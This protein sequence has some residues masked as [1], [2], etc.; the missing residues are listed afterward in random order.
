MVVSFQ[1][2]EE[3]QWNVNA[4]DVSTNGKRGQR[5]S[6]RRVRS[7]RHM[8]GIKSVSIKLKMVRAM[9]RG[10]HFINHY[11]LKKTRLIK[12]EKANYKCEHC[13]NDCNE[14]HH[15]DGGKDNHRIDNL[16]AA[17]HKC[18]MSLYHSSG[19]K[20]KS[21]GRPAGVGNKNSK[22]GPNAVLKELAD[23]IQGESISRKDFAK[24]IGVVP[25]F[26]TM[27]LNGQR[28][29]SLRLCNRIAQETYFEIKL[30]DLRPDIIIK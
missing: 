18:H 28:K 29:A 16:I 13:G 9:K 14:V 8:S 26:L 1:T 23:Y 24:T 2:Q 4:N 10:S 21:V 17:C 30:E 5:E 15:L 27:L 11:E 6:Q 25:S 3:N 19:S 12:L 7:A 20:C 22:T